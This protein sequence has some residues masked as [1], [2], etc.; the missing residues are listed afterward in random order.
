MDAVFHENLSPF[1]FF[2][3]IESF[4]KYYENDFE[5]DKQSMFEKIKNMLNLYPVIIILTGTPQDP[6][7]GYSKTFIEIINKL[8]IR[9]KSYDILK[10]DNLRGWL[11]VYTGWK[12]FP[13]LYINERL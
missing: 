11:R 10:N 3:T 2:K 1:E 7:C 12:T 6:Y 8:E 13:Q 4:Y 5:K 9:Y